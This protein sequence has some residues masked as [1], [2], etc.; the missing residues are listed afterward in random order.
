MNTPENEAP[1]RVHF[2]AGLHTAAGQRVDDSAY[3]QYI[4]RWSRLFVPAVLAA[5]EVTGG[6]RM[7]DVATGP[8]E[9]ALVALSK[10]K[11]AG[12]VIGADISLAMLTAAR[13]R[14]GD[15]SFRP[16]AMDGQ[17]LAFKD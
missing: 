15:D 14:L 5:A 13:A 9:A 1:I 2:G 12:L 10:V 4:G 17:A 8:G 3:Y 6:D 16:V 11:P 7:L